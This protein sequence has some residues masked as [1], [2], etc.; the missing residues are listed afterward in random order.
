MGLEKTAKT[1]GKKRKFESNTVDNASEK[2]RSL[3]ILQSITNKSAKF[4]I[5]SAVTKQIYREDHEKKTEMAKRGARAK[6]RGRQ[7]LTLCVRVEKENSLEEGHRIE[8]GPEVKNNPISAFVIYIHT[9]I[10]FFH[11]KK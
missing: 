4:D 9:K 11:S 8:G 10:N 2:Q 7:R 5:D 3:S 6:A 1:K